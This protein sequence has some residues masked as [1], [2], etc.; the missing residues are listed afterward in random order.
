MILLCWA[1]AVP[2][3]HIG[4]T[5][6]FRDLQLYPDYSRGGTRRSDILAY[7]IVSGW[8][9]TYLALAGI[10][11]QFFHTDYV[12]MA[13]D[14]IY[15]RSAHV[16]QYLLCPMF[17]YQCWNTCICLYLRE[18]RTRV[19]IGHHVL[20]AAACYVSMVS[21]TFQYY[22]VFFC[23]MVELTNI[24]LTIY[25]LFKFFP[26]YK[27]VFPILYRSS[28]LLFTVWFIAI[29]LILWP[30]RTFECL[31]YVCHSLLTGYL[32][33]TAT[34]FFLMPIIILATTL[35]LIWGLSVIRLAREALGSKSAYSTF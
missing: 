35:Q 6:L 3:V 12:A 8:Y 10:N 20:T 31:Q 11:I 7:E 34:L 18:F 15:S 32:Q 25:D 4:L 29:R 16:E 33:P 5:R 13:Q 21:A 9:C 19:M 26:E 14:P 2:L 17:F 22:L 28:R 30:L 23:G 1:L 24:P 27:P